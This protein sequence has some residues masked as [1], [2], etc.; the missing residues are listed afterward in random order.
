MKL[1]NPPLLATWTGLLASVVGSSLLKRARVLLAPGLLLCS[2]TSF[3]DPV[4]WTL[5]NVQTV[6]GI[7]VA[8]SFVYDADTNT[9]SNI[10][11]T[12]SNGKTFTAYDASKV[13]LN[14][15]RGLQ[16]FESPVVPGTSWAMVLALTDNTTYTPLFKTNRGG[17]LTLDTRSSQGGFVICTDS[18]CSNYTST[19]LNSG[20][21]QWAI[22]SLV[23][24]SPY[25]FVDALSPT[26]GPPRGGNTIT[27]TGVNFLGATDVMFGTVSAGA[28]NFTVVNDTTITVTVP[29]QASGIVKVKVVKGAFA[30]PTSN[31][32]GYEYFEPTAA[33]VRILT[34]SSSPSSLINATSTDVGVTVQG[35][36]SYTSAKNEI[37][38]PG[39][40]ASTYRWALNS[41]STGAGTANANGSNATGNTIGGLKTQRGGT[42][43]LNAIS[44]TPVAADL[45][46]YLYYCVT[47]AAVSGIVGPEACSSA[48]PVGPIPGGCGSAH[49]FATARAPSEGLCGAGSASAVSGT[50][51]QWSWSCS[52]TNGGTAP[53][54][55]ASYQT[56]TLTLNANATSVAV[57]GTTVA[58]ASSTSGLKPALGTSTASICSVGTVSPTATGVQA[59]I[60]GLIGGTC[61]VTATLAGTGDTGEARYLAAADQTVDITVNKADQTITGF[62]A[63]KTTLNVGQM[64]TVSAQG[65]ASDNALSF[66]SLSTDVCAVNGAMVTAL[67]AGTCTVAANQAGDDRYKA[68]AQ[69]TLDIAVAK[70][71]QLISSFA[72]NPSSL[73]VGQNA[74]LSASG[75]AS[76]NAVLFSSASSTVCSIS[77]STVT[78]LSAG[79]CEARANQAGNAN[80]NAAAE[81]SLSI[82]VGKA[83]QLIS[84]FTA[85]PSRIKVG[86]TSTLLASGGASGNAVLFS[87]TTPSV[88]TVSGSTVTA[89]AAGDC[90][91]RA[92]QAGNDSFNAAAEAALTIIV[93]A[94]PTAAGVLQ[95]STASLSFGGQMVNTISAV[96]VVTLTNIGGST[97]SKLNLGVSGS[98]ART[99]QTCTKTLAA[100][101][102]C[103]ID[104][105]FAPKK[106]GALTGAI[107]VSSSVAPQSVALSGTGTTPPA[108]LQLS[109]QSLA[110]SDQAVS[111]RSAAQVVTLTNTGGSPI[112][113][114]S[115][116]VSAPFART[117]GTCGKSLAAGAS[118]TI[119]VAFAPRTKGALTGSLS[120]SSDV[121][122]QSVALSGRGV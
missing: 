57:N 120:I 114:L 26:F 86:E 47:P 19:G 37:L 95:L 61:T 90:F 33:N 67:S 100:G 71:E 32:L 104:M 30:T 116:V 89:L 40:P 80:F 51:G 10:N 82:P 43:V 60:T 22:G 73:K 53:S 106:R 52:G 78:A 92:N 38:A 11:I 111:S 110:F 12:A 66:S 91:A 4:T 109:T 20:D 68:A 41:V 85:S 77:G 27:L 87:S 83:E 103:T 69:V 6:S 31:A 2:A 94:A 44:Y 119:S 81:V 121:A 74:M 105:S 99:A 15:K 56:Q 115:L 17:Q 118:C 101:A 35:I 76:G 48:I 8:G 24:V 39:N 16:P 117:A 108:V 55:A 88:C 79:S 42:I 63:V 18:S 107:S 50:D 49:G 122:P 84:G 98:F 70:A 5:S 3:A 96:Q 54:C 25:P 7:T 64:T 62:A 21:T 112:S 97:I 9:H 45:G 46:Q 1:R 113:N 58:N 28:G 72:S 14:S 75:G 59:S 93:D 102:S 65:G 13:I 36:Y 34:G 23:A 29:A